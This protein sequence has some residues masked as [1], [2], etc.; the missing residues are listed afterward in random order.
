[1]AK[2]HILQEISLGVWK[3]IELKISKRKRKRRK[4]QKQK[5]RRAWKEKV[6]WKESYIWDPKDWEI[7][8]KR[9]VHAISVAFAL[10][11]LGVIKYGSLT[12][13]DCYPFVYNPHSGLKLWN[14]Y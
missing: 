3:G 9:D 11:A 5:K 6:W 10:Y 8:W 14:T 7:E 4:S 1:M 12:L 13:F 2:P